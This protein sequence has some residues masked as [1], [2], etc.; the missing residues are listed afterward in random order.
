MPYFAYLLCKFTK[1]LPYSQELRDNFPLEWPLAHY[2]QFAGSLF[3][4]RWLSGIILL[5]SIRRVVF[6]LSQRFYWD[7]DAPLRVFICML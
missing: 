7:K 2:H 3:M 6:S 5:W 1:K 4:F